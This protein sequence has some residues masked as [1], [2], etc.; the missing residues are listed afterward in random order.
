MRREMVMRFIAFAILVVALVS[1]ATAQ[2]NASIQGTVTD[3]SGAVVPGATVTIINQATNAS[4]TA[5]TNDSGLYQIGHLG[6]GN[7]TVTAEAPSFKK[8]SYRDVEVRAETPRGLNIALSPGQ[9]SESVEV[10]DSAGGVETE[11][12]NQQGTISTTQ[13]L[14]LPQAGR[15]PYNLIRLTPGIFGDAARTGSGAARN[16]PQQV[17]PGGSNSQIFQTE[18]QVQVTSNGQRVT[19]NN[20]MLDGV[21]VNSLDWGGAAVITPNQESVQEITVVAGSY[22]AEDGRNL[23]AQVKTVSKSG[24]NRLHGSGVI[25]FNDS[26]LNAF[27]KF[28]G[29]TTGTLKQITCETGTPSQFTITAAQCPERVDQKF[30]QFAGSVGGPVIKDKLFFFFSYEGVRSNNTTLTRSVTLDAPSFDQYVIKTNPNSI[31]AKIFSTPGYAARIASITKQVDCCS[32]DGRALGTWYQPGTGVGQAIG[33]GPDGINDWGVY[34]LRVPNSANGNQYNGRLDYNQGKNQFFFSSYYVQQDNVS[35][36]NRPIEDVSFQPNNEIFTLGWTRTLTNTLLNDIRGNFTRWTFSQL[37][38]SGTTNYGIPQIRVFDFDAGGFGDAGRIAGV[39]RS[40]TTPASLAQN[41]FSIRDNVSWVRGKHVFKFG[42]EVVKEQNNNAL[43]GGYR[44]DYQ[45]RGLLNLANDACC[46]FEEQSINPTTGG[47]PNGSRHF[48]TADYA[49]YA[50]DQWKIRPNLTLT[51]GLRWEYFPPLTETNNLLTNYVYGSQG[52]INGT[53]QQTNQLYNSDK[54]NFS[55]KVGFAWTPFA[56]DS[57]LVFRGGFGIAYNR[58]FGTVF[59]NIRQNT[60]FFAEA[61]TCC[62]FDPG[63]IQG[64]P[65][66][67]NIQY[68]IGT[69][70][71]AFSF[72]PNPSF[73]LGVAPD[74]ALCGNATCSTVTKVDLFGA[75]PNEPNAYSYNF[76]GEVQKEFTRSDVFTIGYHGS[77]TRKL[78]R[79]IDVNRLI[80]GDTFGPNPTT[81]PPGGQDKKQTFTANGTPL[82]TPIL[83]GNNRFNRIFIPLPDVNASFDSMVASWSHR[84]SRGLQLTANYSWSHTIDTGSYEVGFQQTD[85]SN[86]LIDRG[87]ADFDVRQNFSGAVVYQEPF[88]RQGNAL[89]KNTLGGWVIS[90]IISKH[91]GFPWSPLIG[92]CDT[93]NDRN[94][95]GYC[96][97]AP[98]AYF[99]G[100]ITDPSKQQWINGV[101]PNPKTS[102]DVTTRGP[103]ARARNILPGPGYTAVDMSLEKNIS[104]PF[105]EGAALSL[106]AN[107]FNVF[108]I[109]NLSTFAPAT[110]P[111]DILN[112]GQFGKAQNANAGRVV[113]FQLRL[114][115]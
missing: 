93:N 84:M 111:T 19:A 41:T 68:G 82:A 23:G 15:D 7:Y 6:P 88:F 85:P 99:G 97:D 89:L 2:F 114:A 26:G 92:S 65:P 109:L 43:A 87:S 101:F 77:R 55:P 11:T 52:L 48:R 3:T 22:S 78:I 95:D 40:F 72:A 35:G 90:G 69:S 20:I 49:V 13:V 81:A 38:P 98:F 27:N 54:N 12:A 105:H 63:K 57:S 58:D 67:S 74:G 5:V 46:F 79:T 56:S 45:F 53:V 9:R 73:A 71:S 1:T 75:L 64:P 33:N 102:F 18:N 62:F 59:S 29:P 76:E 51:L 103:G 112:T 60:P 70:A 47:V 100:M 113:E 30:R 24:T 94:G 28:Y 91:S 80:P 4:T 104:L 39:G 8:A 106:R 31:A 96:P 50:Q 10:T 86:Q 34:D 108:N 21:S 42:G 37:S 25:K 83:T 107:A 32:L 110:A 17:G 36:G 66:G 115:F 44:P 16:L 14:N 61:S